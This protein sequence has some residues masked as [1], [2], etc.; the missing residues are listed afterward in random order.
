MS[1]RASS[2]TPGDELAETVATLLEQMGENS[3]REGL[4]DTPRR[5]AESLR[6]L[7]E[8]Y[9]ADPQS[10]VGD[11]L[12]ALDGYDDMVV[13]K[14]IAF[15]SLCEHHLLPFF[16]RA[17]IG[18]VPEGRV[19]GLSKLPRL[20]DAYSHRLQIQERMT[21]EIAEAINT[22]VKPRGVGVVVEGRHLCIEMRGVKKESSQTAT[23]CM[24]RMRVRPS[25]PRKPMLLVLGRRSC[26]SP[27]IQTSGSS[28]NSLCSS[29]SRSMAMRSASPCSSRFASLHASPKPTILGTLSV[30]ALE[31]RSCPPPRVNR[32]PIPFGP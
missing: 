5:V 16:G 13:V 1:V 21:R 12:F 25:T 8:G 22:V 3:Y 19:V 15:F 11:A 28:A 20:V 18:Y 31:S 10:I 7:T 24:S 32:A 26:L 14:D 6:F 27:L 30:P 2:L 17:H 23:S 9:A 4:I 29:L